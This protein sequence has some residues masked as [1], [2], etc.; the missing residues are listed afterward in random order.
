MQTIVVNVVV[1]Q[2]VMLLMAI[3]SLVVNRV[4]KNSFVTKVS[5][6]GCS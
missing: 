5:L 2:C 4:G 1:V 3:A 6:N